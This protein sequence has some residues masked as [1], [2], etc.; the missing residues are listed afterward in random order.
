MSAI[1][2]HPLIFVKKKLFVGL[3]MKKILYKIMYI[4]TF[5]L[6]GKAYIAYLSIAIFKKQQLYFMF[7]F[8]YLIC[9]MSIFLK[10]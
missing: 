10:M 3:C 8:I 2:L 1:L 4:F 5:M 6:E 7:I 9:K